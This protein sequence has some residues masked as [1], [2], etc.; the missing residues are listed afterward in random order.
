MKFITQ[1]EALDS[2]FEKV[3][4]PDEESIW[5]WDIG[6]IVPYMVDH[7]EIWW[8]DD[9]NRVSLK[10]MLKKYEFEI[11]SDQKIYRNLFDEKTVKKL[12]IDKLAEQTYGNVMNTEY[13][14]D[15]DFDKVFETI[16]FSYITDLLNHKIIDYSL[17][18]EIIP[19]SDYKI[20]LTDE[21]IEEIL[22]EIFEDK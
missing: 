12:F 9:Y 20:K 22:N 21:E 14:D 17:Y 11:I 15:R 10:E 8:Q 18:P 2:G 6:D 7:L 13:I 19:V 16:D 1:K 3:I 4:N 5:H